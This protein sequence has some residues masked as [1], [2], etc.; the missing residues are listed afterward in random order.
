[1]RFHQ[2]SRQS[3]VVGNPTK[4]R[5]SSVPRHTE[6]NGILAQKICKD[7]EIPKPRKT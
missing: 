5:R 2:G 6:V 4:N 7:L 3:L 1:M